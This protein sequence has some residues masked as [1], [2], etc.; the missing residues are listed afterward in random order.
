MVLSAF[1]LAMRSVGLGLRLLS[2]FQPSVLLPK[3][4]L[5]AFHPRAER[6]I[7]GGE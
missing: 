2:G 7:V 3:L 5:W 1:A 6:C 4:R